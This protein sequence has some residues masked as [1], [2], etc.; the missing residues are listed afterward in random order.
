[1]ELAVALLTML[2]YSYSSKASSCLQHQ[3]NSKIK[4]V[5]PAK[6]NPFP[7]NNDLSSS[8]SAFKTEASPNTAENVCDKGTTAH[9]GTGNGL[10]YL[11]IAESMEDVC[12]ETVAE[13]VLNA[14]IS[15]MQI[16]TSLSKDNVN[17]S[18]H[19]DDLLL[20]ADKPNSLNVHHILYD[21]IDNDESNPV[22]QEHRTRL[23]RH[24][25]GSTVQ[26]MNASVNSNCAHAPPGQTPGH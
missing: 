22:I 23:D 12:S 20:I 6:R 17:R 11:L 10:H 15:A 8:W 25:A 13:S 4:C 2:F 16:M 26:L 14:A 9:T 3:C 5:K 18:F 7:K 19:P 21:N 24:L 1:M